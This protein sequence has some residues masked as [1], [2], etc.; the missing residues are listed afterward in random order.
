VAL[1]NHYRRTFPAWIADTVSGVSDL[2]RQILQF[3]Y[4]L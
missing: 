3:G 1:T 2:L 4:L